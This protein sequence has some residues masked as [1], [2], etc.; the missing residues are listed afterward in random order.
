PPITLA[1][2]AAAPKARLSA[3]G[4]DESI[5]GARTIAPAVEVFQIGVAPGTRRQVRA[6]TP[7]PAARHFLRGNGVCGVGEA[8]DA[9][10]ATMLTPGEMPTTDVPAPQSLGA[11]VVRHWRRA[12]FQLTRRS[13]V[14]WLAVKGVLTALVFLG[15]MGVWTAFA[16]DTAIS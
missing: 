11:T 10:A 6:G 13:V 1:A 14:P 9:M 16:L 2:A 3:S 8:M 4:E 5:G 12:P 15:W 7:P